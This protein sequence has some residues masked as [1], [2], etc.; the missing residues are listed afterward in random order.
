MGITIEQY[1]ARIGTYNNCVKTKDIAR[2]ESIFWNTR[3]IVVLL[4][5][6]LYLLGCTVYVALLL[7]MAND[8]E[9]NPGPTLYDIVDPSKTI[10]ADFSQSNA[11]K[12]RH[13]AGKQCVAMSLTAIVQTQVKDITTWDSSFLNE[14]LSVGNNLY[15][16]I[17]NS[18]NHDYLLLS[19]VPEMVSVGNK[20]YCLQYSESFSGDVFQITDEEPFYMLK[21]A[22][23]KIFSPTE[24]SYRH[25]LLTIDC[26]TVAVC[27]ISEGMFK[28]FDSHSRDLYGI[29]DPFGKCVLIHVER[30]DNL[31]GFFQNTNPPNTTTPFEVKGV[32]SS[33]LN[34]V[35]D[36]GNHDIEQ[37]KILDERE[38]KL[39]KRRQKYKERSETTEARGQRLAKLREMRKNQSSDSREKSLLDKR[40]R[41]QQNIT[42]ESSEARQTRLLKKCEQKKQAI[43]RETTEQRQ[44][45]LLAKRRQK[46]Q[47]VSRETIE[48]REK[49]LLAKRQ[50]TKQ[51]VESE[52]TEQREIRLIK[53][54]RRNKLFIMSQINKKK[55]G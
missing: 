17:H 21:T 12:F 51:A 25:C 28:I 37:N 41:V 48:Q 49:R 24:L 29:P 38:I 53:E 22:L 10:C 1:R 20:V 44:R 31:S 3:T 14:I 19:D 15:T 54:N 40:Q 39:K 5:R 26:N 23:S 47:A 45:R 35:I 33:L 11:R 4:T 27:M 16:Y 9:E 42:N 13:N 18:V 50:Q 7:R 55:I 30:L 36:N 52:T 6:R 43:E 32:K 2:F 46:K 8:V 34:T